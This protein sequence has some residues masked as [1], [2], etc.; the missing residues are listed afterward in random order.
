MVALFEYVLIW[1]IGFLCSSSILMWWFRTG[2]PIHVF[3]FIKKLGYKKKDDEFW[4]SDTPIDLWTRAD[5]EEFAAFKLGLL[6][7]L[8]L[9]PGCLSAHIS[10]AVGAVTAWA[11]QCWW[12]L[13][14]FWL[15]WPYPLNLALK[16]LS[17]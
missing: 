5:F 8:L 7:E 1:I 10:L 11:F 9:C 2:L 3:Q 6:G 14:V 16:K 12:L 15:S 13:P 17:N 4:A